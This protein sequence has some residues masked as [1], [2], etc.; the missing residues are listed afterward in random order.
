MPSVLRMPEVAADTPSATLSAWPVREG[1]RFASGETLFIV[2]TA[3]AAVDVA[4]EADGVLVKTLVGEGSEVT[5]GTAIAVLAGL[6]ETVGD[7]DD[8]LARLNLT[9]G[10]GRLFASPIARRLAR[11]AGLELA[12]ITA[13]GP[14]GRII[15]RDIE[16]AIATAAPRPVKQPEDQ[17]YHDVP[18]T[19]VRRAIAA[20]LTESQQTVPHFYL[21][22]TATVDRLLALRA[23]LNATG[24]AR[25]SVSDLIVKAVAAAHRR[26]PALN[27][28]WTPD[29]VR[30]YD[31]VDVAVAVATP[32]GLVTPVLRE[33]DRMTIGALS[34]S[35]RDLAERARGG[36]LQQ[37]ELDGGT[38]T[39]SNLGMYGVTEFAAIIN[40]PQA[41]ILAVGAASR[42]PVI[43]AGGQVEA[44]TVL[45][46]TL[47]VDHRPVDGAVAA[48]WLAGLVGLLEQPAGILL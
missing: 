9:A 12:G 7:L 14:G 44:A 13:T 31:T 29:A 45:S 43:T 3:K 39:V 1:Q 21:R 47:S 22:A 4:A 46:L 8:V 32:S 19:P 17:P 24:L 23:E 25:I 42:Q 10:N 30:H 26:T 35:L 2:E 5:V 34:A 20:R 33:V 28:T 16:A 41:A 36:R 18:H 40:P 11:E 38:I 6:G 15:R 27:V 48:A 37:R